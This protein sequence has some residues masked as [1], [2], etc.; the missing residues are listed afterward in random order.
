MLGISYGTWQ[1][2]CEMYFSLPE[3]TLRAYLQWFPF[4]KL[5]ASDKKVLSSYDF[6]KCYV[7]DDAFVMFPD[8]ML[9]TENY[10]QKGDGSFRDSSLLSPMLY[11]VLQAAGKEIYNRY[12]TTRADSVD[13][14]YAGN[15]SI[16]DPKYKRSYDAFFKDINSSIDHY[17]YYLKTDIV[18]FFSN[19]NVDKLIERIDRVCNKDEV[20]FSQTQLQLFKEFLLYCGDGQFPLVENSMASSYFATEIYLEE[21]DNRLYNFLADHMPELSHFRMVRYVDDLYIL[22]DSDEPFHRITD[23]CTEIRNEYSSI[24]KD[25]NLSLNTRKC[26]YG[27]T[28]NI[29]DELKKSMYDE[30]FNGGKCDIPELFA[31]Q[32]ESFLNDLTIELLFDSVDHDK[33]ASK[34]AEYFTRKDV[35]FTANEVFNYFVYENDECLREE[36]ISNLI[37]A[38][39]Q[40]SISFV[41]LDPKRLTVMILKTKKGK[42]IRSFLSKL[43]QKHSSGKWNSYDTVIAISYLIQRGFVQQK[44]ISIIR[45]QCPKLYDYYWRYCRISFLL[46]FEKQ[47]INYFVQLLGG[48]A[49]AYFL[50]FMHLCEQKRNNHMSSFAYFKTYFDRITADLAFVFSRQGRDR[51]PAYERYYKKNHIKAFYL[52]I[53]NSDAIITKAHDIRDSNPLCHASAESL[54]TNDSAITMNQNRKDLIKLIAAY[55]DAHPET[56]LVE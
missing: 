1:N 7:K 55:L 36:K 33:Y 50:Y 8:T 20:R 30:M 12:R 53:E 4:S 42:T 45:E 34:M 26:S 28:S 14:Y 43:F 15:Y 54:S 6:Y 5:S 49:T 11:L 31:G 52:G 48:D 21:V 27:R 46:G 13:I 10:I 2:I 19:I 23:L 41:C 37:G 40:Q 29:N 18:N 16:K 47:K 56:P 9:Q 22:F 25:F 38:L 24:L 3:K 35:E 44:L 39:V 17:Q 51:K 32:L